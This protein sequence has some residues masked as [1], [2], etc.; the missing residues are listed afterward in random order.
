[1]SQNAQ[2]FLAAIKNN[3]AEEASKYYLQDRSV[4]FAKDDQKRTA[5]QIAAMNQYYDLVQYL[6]AIGV[7][8]D[9]QDNMCFN[10]FLWGC[11]HNDL[12]LVKTMV[13]AG[14]DLE[15]LTRFGGNGLTPAS[16]KGNVEVV[17]YL[18]TQTDI[19]PNHTNYLGWTALIEAATLKGD[20]E[21]QQKVVELLL[22][23]GADPNMVDPYGK[24]PLTLA[25]DKGHTNIAK[26]IALHGGI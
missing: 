8:L 26:I 17:E 23:Y 2:D 24:T 16:E 13:E 3:Y 14:A 22:T 19:N 20:D 15:R 11:I 7:D 18:L 10:P 5:L 6:I 25:T 21:R 4:I 1:M 9:E 12:K